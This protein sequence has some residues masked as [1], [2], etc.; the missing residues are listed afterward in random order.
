VSSGLVDADYDGSAATAYDRE[1]TALALAA[2]AAATATARTAAAAAC[3]VSSQNRARLQQTFLQARLADYEHQIQR[4][5]DS[6]KVL[7]LA[8]AL[9]FTILARCSTHS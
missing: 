1:Q 5:A 3:R 7:L 8:T 6:K 4:G 9:V 2:A